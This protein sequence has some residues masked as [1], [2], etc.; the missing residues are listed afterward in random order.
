MLTSLMSPW[1]YYRIWPKVKLFIWSLL[2]LI[3]GWIGGMGLFNHFFNTDAQAGV[4]SMTKVYET[5]V[6]LNEFEAVLKREFKLFED[7]PE[8]RIS[9]VYVLTSKLYDGTATL[10]FEYKGME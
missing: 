7:E 8:W 9:A 2:I 6:P 4:S 10:Q 3:I 1:F 5:S